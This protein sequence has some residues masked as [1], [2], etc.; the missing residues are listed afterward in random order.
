[1][2]FA[3]F[4]SW[5]LTF[6]GTF[7]D[8]RSPPAPFLTTVDNGLSSP[9]VA[10]FPKITYPTQNLALPLLASEATFQQTPH[11]QKKNSKCDSKKSTDTKRRLEFV[12]FCW[13]KPEGRAWNCGRWIMCPEN[14]GSS[15]RHRKVKEATLVNE[16]PLRKASLFTCSTFTEDRWILVNGWVIINVIKKLLLLL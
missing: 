3:I 2:K 12:N 16:N 6:Y 9:V 8:Y 10:F 4:E 11:H 1:M 14:A 7:L 5:N 13:R 15:G